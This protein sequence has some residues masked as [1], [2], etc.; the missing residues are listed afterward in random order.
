MNSVKMTHY[1]SMN[2][3]LTHLDTVTGHNFQTRQH[4]CHIRLTRSARGS[5][6]SS[7]LQ[8][9]TAIGRK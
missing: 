6:T 9:T 8:C 4:D 3:S 5:M 1:T 7:W 2:C